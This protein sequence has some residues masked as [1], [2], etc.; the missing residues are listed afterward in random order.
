M[1]EVTDTVRVPLA[2]FDWTYARA[3]GPGGQNVNKVSSKALLRWPL[4]ASPSVTPEVKARLAR[5]YPARMTT[6]GDFLVT[7][8]KYRDQERNRADCLEKLA[9]MIRKAA[10]LP[11]ARRPTK[12]SKASNR[13]R[14]ADKKRQAERKSDRRGPAGE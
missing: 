6:T 4:D 14:L 10:E 8:Q 7:S 5:L 13:R 9:V 3:G 1:L 2:E 12:P 11:T